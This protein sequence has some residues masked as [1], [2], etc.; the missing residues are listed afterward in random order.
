M[1]EAKKGPVPTFEA[2]LKIPGIP[3]NSS[4]IPWNTS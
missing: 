3:S 1:R 2:T 4:A